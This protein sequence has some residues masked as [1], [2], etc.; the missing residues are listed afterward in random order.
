MP[1]TRVP[2]VTKA[3]EEPTPVA[4]AENDAG[5]V[6]TPAPTPADPNAE[7]ETLPPE[8][9]RIIITLRDGRGSIGVKRFGWDPY[10][11]TMTDSDLANALA[12]VPEVLA[13]ADAR[14]QERHQNPKYTRPAPV[15]RPTP[16]R[17]ARTPPAPAAPAGPTQN[18][19]F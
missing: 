3:Q 15:L 1:R 17:A 9:L 12:L 11:A 2:K 6:S 16:A 5:A 18:N 8:Y 13:A 7:E 4:E 10:M 14:W 19:L